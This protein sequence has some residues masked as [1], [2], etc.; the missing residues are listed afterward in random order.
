VPVQA[1]RESAWAG[2]ASGYGVR[3]LAEA[4]AVPGPRPVPGGDT[5]PMRA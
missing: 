2:T 1:Y 3:H 4:H 5:A